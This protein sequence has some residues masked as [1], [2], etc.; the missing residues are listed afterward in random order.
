VSDP[1]L[2]K[3]TIITEIA[4]L[5]T[6][7]PNGWALTA[8]NLGDGY[9]KAVGNFLK[10]R[11]GSRSPVVGY[12]EDSVL[13][14]DKVYEGFA[15]SRAAIN[16]ADLELDKL[17]NTHSVSIEWFYDRSKSYV[18]I[19][20]RKLSID[21]AIAENCV[22]EN[23]SSI[24]VMSENS[25]LY[26]CGIEF[27]DT[28]LVDKRFS[29]PN[30]ANAA[31][32]MSSNEAVANE[33]AYEEISQSLSRTLTE[34]FGSSCYVIRTFK[35]KALCEVYPPMPDYELATVH[36]KM[37]WVSF[38]V[39]RDKDG[40]VSC[41]LDGEPE[42]Y[43]TSKRVA[44][45]GVQNHNIPIISLPTD[46]EKKPTSV[47]DTEAK[48]RAAHRKLGVKL[49]SIRNLRRDG[50]EV[51]GDMNFSEVLADLSDEHKSAVAA[52][53]AEQVELARNEEQAKAADALEAFK[54]TEVPKLIAEAQDVAR[55]AEDVFHNRLSELATIHPIAD[56]EKDALI[57]ELREANDL[58]Y[59]NLKLR[60]K[61]TALENKTVT[62]GDDEQGE[63]PKVDNTADPSGP[64]LG[65]DGQA[66]TKTEVFIL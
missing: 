60:R 17:A 63:K 24:R 64:A 51:I 25:T 8:D 7:T 52:L 3:A 20:D 49:E 45:L 10:I 37:Y 61:V 21:E 12:C 9:K 46:N 27:S 53:V 35:S 50:K 2:T 30:Y 42:L 22:E 4:Q 57:T 39:K 29:E 18:E 11:H 5:N 43:E 41:T 44:D 33:V 58:Q 34:K 1:T 48:V 15:L 36:S 16:E 19:E 14:G 31:I 56:D 23:G 6:R 59:E 28:A 32:I 62:K 13:K 66:V 54:T 38:V 55:N 47:I 40:I 26:P 65:K